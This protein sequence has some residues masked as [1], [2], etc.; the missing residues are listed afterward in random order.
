MD[1]AVK[2]ANAGLGPVLGVA[3]VQG[4]TGKTVNANS[5][6]VNAAKAANPNAGPKISNHGV[7]QV[8]DIKN[9]RH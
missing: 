8:I 4:A 6:I 1:E 3:K 5:R 2:P 7:L 9:T